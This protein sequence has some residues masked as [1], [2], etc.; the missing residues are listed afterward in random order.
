[1]A[2]PLRLATAI[3][4]L[5]ILQAVAM[6]SWLGALFGQRDIEVITNTD[7]T[8]DGQS[9]LAASPRR[10]PVRTQISERG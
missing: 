10:A 9:W 8:P 2:N 4:I 5:P 7:V 1:M 3:V 6:A